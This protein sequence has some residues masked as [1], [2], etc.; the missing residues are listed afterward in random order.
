M[1]ERALRGAL[2]ALCGWIIVMGAWPAQTG[3]AAPTPLFQF[4]RV[5]GNILPYTVTID[6]QGHISSSG[7][8]VLAYPALTLSADTLAG[9][10]TLAKAERFSQLPAVIAG[11]HTLPD[12]ASLF[13]GM[14][15]GSVMKQV[16][17]HGA[18]S[19]RF[20]QLF[21]ILSAVTGVGLSTGGHITPL[22]TLP[23]LPLALAPAC[24]TRQVL[25]APAT[26]S[27]GVGHLGLMFQISNVSAAACS[28]QGYPSVQLL[29]AQG[30]N[31]ATH[32]TR[33]AGYLSGVHTVHL[34]TI[35]PG[36]SAYLTLEWV[37]IPSPGESCPL[38]QT[39]ALSLGAVHMKV[40][41]G[42]Q[43]IDACG[44]RITASPLQAIPIW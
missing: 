30:H 12:I 42:M 9:L 33:G 4:G 19:A 16:R 22:P 41:L 11:A 17:E 10:A 24:V 38:A 43:G 39:V 36:H 27:G 28:A 1:R 6:T 15:I 20:D 18:R 13:I 44:G 29:N 3:A 40:A 2:I 25:I 5:G 37:H 34:I 21:A 7:P 32:E 26:G 14:P 8:I 35:Q 31:L 23:Q